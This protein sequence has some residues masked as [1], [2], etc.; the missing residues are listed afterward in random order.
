M[1]FLNSKEMRLIIKYYILLKGEFDMRTYN[2]KKVKQVLWI[3]LVANFMVSFTKI[4][5]GISIKSTS[6]TADGFHSFSDGASNIVGIIGVS[7]ASKPKDKKHPYGHKKFEIIASMF[8]G[9]MLLVMAFKIVLDA[10]SRFTNPIIPSIT[11]ESLLALVGTLIINI[12]VC[13]YEYKVGNKLNSHILIS[14]SIHT[15]SDI[16]VSIGVLCSLIGVKLGLPPIIDPIASL[17]V[18]GVILLSSYEIFKSAT[19]VLVDSAIVDDK[20][21]EN[22]IKNID[23]V[24]GVH[25]IRS[26]GSENDIYIDMH[27]LVNPNINVEESHKLAHDIEVKIKGELNENAQV[28]VHIEPYYEN[29]RS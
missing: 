18:A 13:T 4:I 5:I 1:D 27:I 25:K 2:Y 15:R 28:I 14:D 26:R 22:I 9:A 7:M 6:M 24:R 16:L 19:S 21:I 17:I 10:I 12:F 11:N 3:I 20:D 29:Y 23:G 8:I